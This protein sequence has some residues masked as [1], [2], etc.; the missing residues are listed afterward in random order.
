[1]TLGYVYPLVIR[2]PIDTSVIDD[3]P[4]E[5]TW[6][7]AEIHRERVHGVFKGEKLRIWND[8]IERLLLE[9]PAKDEPRA[10][11]LLTDAPGQLAGVPISAI[12]RVPGPSDMVNIKV[13]ITGPAGSLWVDHMGKVI[14]WVIDVPDIRWA[15]PVEV[16]KV[17]VEDDPNHVEMWLIEDQF[18]IVI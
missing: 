16:Y 14:D 8:F 6:R 13:R 3:Q 18:E 1:M 7:L 9:F 10:L 15:D 17:R 12:D 5:Y 2:C 4:D 11:A